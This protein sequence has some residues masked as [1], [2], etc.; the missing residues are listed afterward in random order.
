MNIRKSIAFL[1]LACLIPDLAL[2]GE[3]R[4]VSDTLHSRSLEGNLLGDSADRSVLVYLPPN[5]VN[6]PTKRYPVV[7]LLHG[8]GRHNHRVDGGRIPRIEY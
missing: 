4:V 7:Y 6:A 3:S 8:N 2:A 1:V 5:Y